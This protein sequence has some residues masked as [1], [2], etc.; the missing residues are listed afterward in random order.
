MLSSR[1][2]STFVFPDS[3]P[4]LTYLPCISHSL[5]EHHSEF[6]EEMEGRESEEWTWADANERLSKAYE[7][8]GLA[9]WM[10]VAEKELELE[11]NNEQ[12]RRAQHEGRTI[13]T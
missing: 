3:I 12:R 13:G 8:G 11:V 1:I 5:L 10:E 6:T 2:Y 9:Q 4:F 7:E